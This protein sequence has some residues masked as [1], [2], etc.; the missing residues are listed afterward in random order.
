VPT[1]DQILVGEREDDML[2]RRTEP[3]FA[4]ALLLG[5]GLCFAPVL[6]ACIQT[7]SA[8]GGGLENRVICLVAVIFLMSQQKDL[9][10][11]PLAGLAAQGVGFLCLVSSLLLV[12]LPLLTVQSFALAIAL[13]GLVVFRWGK[14]GWKALKKP[15]IIITMILTVSGV[16]N[17]VLPR[18]TPIVPL[19]QQFVAGSAA[20]I[21]WLCGLPATVHDTVLQIGNA[22]GVDVNAGCSGIHSLTEIGVLAI[23]AILT[24]SQRPL[25]DNL[26]YFFTCEL[27]VLGLNIFRILLLAYA[28]TNL[29]KET[30]D[31]L[32]EG[33]G[34]SLYGNAISIVA[35][36][37]TSS[38][39]R[40]N[41]FDPQ[42]ASDSG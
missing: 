40:W 27:I 30:F 8:A 16:A 6:F 32:H 19:L 34:A 38:F 5:L 14:P 31:A 21:L 17:G 9:L 25:K 7:W 15:L 2:I 1:T 4:L 13:L 33:W 29:G 41:P 36:L 28:T 3:L 42:S 10:K 18:Y 20:Y 26:R 22:G 11:L 39:F 37:Y 35:I 12:Q 23:T 24:I